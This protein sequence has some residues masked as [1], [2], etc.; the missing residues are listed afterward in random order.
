MHPI[1]TLNMK[2]KDWDEFMDVKRS[3]LADLKT[4]LTILQDRRREAAY[5]TSD[6]ITS[7]DSTYFSYVISV[8]ENKSPC[9]SVNTLAASGRYLAYM[10]R[11]ERPPKGEGLVYRKGKVLSLVD[12]EGRIEFARIMMGLLGRVCTKRETQQILEPKVSAEENESNTNTERQ[13]TGGGGTLGKLKKSTSSF[14]YFFTIRRSGLKFKS[15][16]KRRG[17]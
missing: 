14:L 10:E 9:V 16:E 15:S 13:A 6:D 12:S 1:I 11:G 8:A 7:R 4:L 17:G 2:T 5:T 3:A